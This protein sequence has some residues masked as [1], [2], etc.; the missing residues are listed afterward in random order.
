MA[1]STGKLARVAALFVLAAAMPVVALAETERAGARADRLLSPLGAG[2]A[3]DPITHALR[4]EEMRIGRKVVMRRPSLLER[5]FSGP[6]ADAA[7]P[8]AL[9]QVSGVAPQ[10]AVPTPT[11]ARKQW[12]LFLD[13]AR[14]LGL[15]EASESADAGPVLAA[16]DMTDADTRSDG[17]RLTWASA[18]NIPPPM[19]ETPRR[20]MQTALARME[21]LL[22]PSL[23]PITPY[24]LPPPRPHFDVHIEPR[25]VV[26]PFVSRRHHVSERHAAALSYRAEPV[27]RGKLPV[28][29]MPSLDP[30]GSRPEKPVVTGPAFILPFEN[31]R[32]TSLFN[33]GRR[34][35][36]IDLAGRH[37]APVYATSSGQVVIFAGG[38]GGYGNA[39]ITRDREGREH[40]YGHLSAIHARVGATLAQG[41]RLGLLGSTGYSTGPHVHYEVKDRRGA[42]INPVT[43]LF[44]GRAVRSGYAWSGTGLAHPQVS[45]QHVAATPPRARTAFKTTRAIVEDE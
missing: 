45:A 33:E 22:R 5:L 1:Y 32:I 41:E 16:L 18:P 3:L 30:F 10:Q 2:G 34:H 38:R 37:G 8:A 17:P 6:A 40:L 13:P 26:L 29:L 24:L 42:H 7:P 4:S 43:L 12:P 36:A 11:M 9:S 20:S 44:P 19:S 23:H 31:G 14:N 25:P 35:P 15:P 27:W 28:S 21:P 39:V